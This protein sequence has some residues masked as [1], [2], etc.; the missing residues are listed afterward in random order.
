M[1]E[2][3]AREQLVIMAETWD[4]LAQEREQKLRRNSDENWTGSTTEPSSK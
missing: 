3:D 4:R 2:G 1:P